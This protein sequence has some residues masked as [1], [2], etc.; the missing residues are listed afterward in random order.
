[1]FFYFILDCQSCKKIEVTT[2][3]GVFLGNGKTNFFRANQVNGRTSWTSDRA[4]LWYD[5]AITDWKIGALNKLGTSTGYVV[6]A[7]DNPNDC[8]WSNENKDKWKYYTDR[9]G[10]YKWTY[11]TR[12]QIRVRCAEG[13]VFERH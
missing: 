5:S 8:P 3:D 2:Y 4:A 6:T 9:T 13:N 1:M 12:N 7:N 10:S 11:L